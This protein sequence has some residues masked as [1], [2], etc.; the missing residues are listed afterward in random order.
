MASVSS[1]VCV[2]GARTAVRTVHV[3]SDNFEVKVG[4]HQ[5][6]VLNPLLFEIVIEAIVQR[7]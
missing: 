3:N 6:S 5:G 4:M 2:R 7:I 1:N